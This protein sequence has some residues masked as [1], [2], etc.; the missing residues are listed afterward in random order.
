M[1]IIF[2]NAWNGKVRSQIKDFI[3]IHALDTDVFCFQ[4]AYD[5]MRDLC[6]PSLEEFQLVK[7]YKYVKE[8]E[9]F[10]QATY[11]KNTLTLVS[12]STLL[13]DLPNVGLG[14]H[15]EL[16][17]D[18][19]PVYLCNFHGISKPGKKT[20]TAKR[21]EQSQSMLAFYENINGPKIIGGDFNLELDTE[22]ISM[23]E[24][25]GYRNLIKDFGIKNTRNR[26]VWDKYPES[27]QYYSDY[28]LVSPEIDVNKFLMPEVE[29]SDHQPMILDFN[30]KI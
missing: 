1:K 30:L 13:K 18:G 19:K 6:L 9:D 24:K 11:I 12:S 3:T 7:D 23:F 2:L 4:E 22:S 15:T 14:L 27:K 16:E 8:G 28:V 29:I 10:T 26:F 17:V 20:D 25:Q 5:E 21:L